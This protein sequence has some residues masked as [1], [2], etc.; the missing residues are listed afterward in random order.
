MWRIFKRV[1][2]GANLA[3]AYY[4]GFSKIV[5]VYMRMK[6]FIYYGCAIDS[7]KQE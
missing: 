2:E 5:S 3:C 7:N 1:N 6:L 4:L